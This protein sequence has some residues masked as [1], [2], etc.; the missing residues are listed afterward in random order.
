AGGSLGGCAKL[1]GAHRHGGLVEGV[2]VGAGH[3]RIEVNLAESRFDEGGDHGA[4]AIHGDGGRLVLPRIGAKVI[5]AEDDAVGI[6]A[7]AGGHD[8]DEILEAGGGHAGIA[9]ELV[10]LVAGR[11]DQHRLVVIGITGQ[12]RAQRFGVRRTV[13]GNADRFA[14][15]VGRRNLGE[16][17]HG[18]RSFRNAAI[19]A[20]V[21][22]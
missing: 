2:V 22:L 20:S 15:A 6:D 17:V 10:D 19:S 4:G 7:F 21:E 12:H 11:L 8:V 1:G 13:G 3:R 16:A 14:V 5:A 18:V 9:A